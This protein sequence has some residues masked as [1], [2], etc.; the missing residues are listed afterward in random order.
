MHRSSSLLVGEHRP[1]EIGHGD[2]RPDTDLRE[3]VR[4]LAD[5][6]GGALQFLANRVVRDLDD[7]TVL[8]D[9]LYLAVEQAMWHHRPVH[10][11]GARTRLWAHEHLPC[12]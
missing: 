12:G 11:V 5:L 9:E 10:D 8:D 3:I 4:V 6:L 2:V 1:Y 7:G